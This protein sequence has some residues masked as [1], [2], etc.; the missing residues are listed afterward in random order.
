MPTPAPMAG[1][2]ALTAAARLPLTLV[3][4]I[5]AAPWTSIPANAA[6]AR[7]PDE[8]GTLVRTVLWSTLL[9]T[10]SSEPST[11]SPPELAEASPPTLVEAA[12]LSN[13]IVV[14]VIVAFAPGQS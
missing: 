8:G 2:V 4:R 7:L 12:S 10:R 11:S 5:V 6:D 14:P 3:L 13:S 1:P 9:S